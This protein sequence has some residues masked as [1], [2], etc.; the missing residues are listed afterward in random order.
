MT[1]LILGQS[2]VTPKGVGR[3]DSLTVHTAGVWLTH[4]NG[5]SLTMFHPSD[6]APWYGFDHE[7]LLR[8][9]EKQGFLQQQLT[10]IE[11]MLS[12]NPN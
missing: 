2:V 9:E 1:D 10:R 3:L 12:G 6:V 8:I 4:S 11:E 7:A 5:S